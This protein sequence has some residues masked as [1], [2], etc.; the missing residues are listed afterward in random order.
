MDK[1]LAVAWRFVS[2]QQSRASQHR[3]STPW[4]NNKNN[5]N[6]NNNNNNYSN[7]NAYN[8]P[9]KVSLRGATSGTWRRARSLS[10]PL[11]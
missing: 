7:D 3:S 9:A 11:R 8:S 6:N 1:W 10:T 4:H 2:D 5:S